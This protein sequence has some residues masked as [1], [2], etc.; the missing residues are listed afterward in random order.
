MTD[1]AADHSG[2]VDMTEYLRDTIR[3]LD[4]TVAVFLERRQKLA[5]RL[6]VLEAAE[7]PTVRG[8]AEDYE[9]R[10]R[11]DRPYETAEPAE[12]VIAEAHRR[13]IG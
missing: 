9:R 12:D 7:D 1:A 2:V 3:D 8:V 11:E 13:Y 4:D 6:A 10:V 5:L